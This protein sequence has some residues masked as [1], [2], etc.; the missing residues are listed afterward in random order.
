MLFD[1]KF[2]RI[3]LY[4]YFINLYFK[5]MNKKMAKIKNLKSLKKYNIPVFK[6]YGVK[7]FKKNKT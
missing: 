3:Y 1:V 5:N 7:K 4:N 6:E 2:S